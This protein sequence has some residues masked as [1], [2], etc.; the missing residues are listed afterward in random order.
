MILWRAELKE[1]RSGAT[2]AVGAAARR[3]AAARKGATGGATSGAHAAVTGG[4]LGWVP[5]MH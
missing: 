3:G 1:K 5:C 2:G 4:A